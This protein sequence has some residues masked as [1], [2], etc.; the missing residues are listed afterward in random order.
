MDFPLYKFNESRKKIEKR[1]ASA[2][3][4]TRVDISQMKDMESDQ[5]DES[6]VNPNNEDDELSDVVEEFEMSD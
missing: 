4:D 5:E 3:Q 6:L 2:M 1:V